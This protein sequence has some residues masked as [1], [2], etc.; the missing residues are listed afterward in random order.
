MITRTV[1]VGGVEVGGG[2]PVR[3]QGM[4]KSR[5]DDTDALLEEA[6]LMAA[7]GAEMIR[8]AVPGSGDAPAIYGLLSGVG[9]PLIADCHFQTKT[10]LASL[11]AGF[12]KVRLNPG[13]MSWEGMAEVMEIAGARGA[14]IRFGFNRGSYEADG[15]VEL[16]QA[17]LVLDSK[18]RSTGFDNFII[19]LK[20]S[21]VAQTVDANRY[22]SMHS[23]TPLHIGVTATG[24]MQDGI[25]K[26]SAGLGCLMLDGV[27]DTVRVSLTGSSIEE[28]RIA[29]MLVSIGEDKS[30]TLQVISC[31]TCS[32][33]RADV[34]GMLDD[35]MK[36]LEDEDFKK[37]LKVA[38]MGCEVN[39]P[40]EAKECD[41]GICST[42][43][44]GILI[45][46]GNIEG[47]LE[48]DGLVD[49]LLEEMRKL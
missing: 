35:F 3:I 34:I 8:C 42:K 10:A 6:R 21:S 12:H 31:P 14:A 15:P 47:T 4:L 26:S 7:A 44:G 30:R 25:V 2:N 29:R 40:G 41:I 18:I 9:V 19:S 33:C 5:L 49:R 38:I 28:I 11:E 16:A 27:G 1:Q 39:G 22:F 32:R 24:P 46:H 36:K 17:A 23:D 13:N 48:K 45:K 43:K 20:S 37:P